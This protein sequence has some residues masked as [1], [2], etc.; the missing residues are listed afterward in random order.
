MGAP[1]PD[2]S[3]QATGQ[4]LEKLQQGDH[5]FDPNAEPEAHP[6]DDHCP[7]F[8][9]DLEEGEGG[10]EEHKDGCEASGSGKPR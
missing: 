7:D 9:A 3:P 6:E 5:V 10:A 1:S 8:D 4:L 2:S